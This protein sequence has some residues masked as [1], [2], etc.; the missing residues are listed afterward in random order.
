MEDGCT[1]PILARSLCSK[2]YQRAT[3]AGTL[4]PKVRVPL[5]GVPCAVES[6]EKKA[7]SRS[8][9]AAHVARHRRYGLSPEEMA[10][11][12]RQEVCAL[13]RVRP[14]EHMDHDHSTGI[15]RAAL[16]AMCNKGLG[17]FQ[18]DP[19]LLRRAAA[20]IEAHRAAAPE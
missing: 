19:D 2:H 17:H 16:C 12:D 8:L 18:D 6:C 4:P 15:T 10:V 20:Y 1:S 11:V 3:A 14:P 13:C 9:C 7:V 5:A